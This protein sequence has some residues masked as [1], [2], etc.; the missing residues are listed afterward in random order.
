MKALE[1]IQ[2]VQGKKGQHVQ[3]VWARE[4]KVKKSCNFSIVKRTA[5]WVRSGI[6]YANLAKVKE[7]IEMGEREEVKPIWNG[8]GEWV[9]FP[10]I[11]RHKETGQEYVRLYPAVFDNLKN[12][13]RVEWLM[14]GVVASYEQVEPYLMGSEKRNADKEP[15]DCFSL[16]PENIIEIAG[17]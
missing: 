10:F 7:G 14:D 11:F 12:Q 13:T 3:A 6:D 5:A 16:K 1:V 15:A 17:E 9:Q 4:A 8:K 2:A